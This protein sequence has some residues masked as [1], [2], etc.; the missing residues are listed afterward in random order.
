MTLDPW[1]IVS[2]NYEHRHKAGWLQGLESNPHA[3]AQ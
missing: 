3:L 1:L 2:Q